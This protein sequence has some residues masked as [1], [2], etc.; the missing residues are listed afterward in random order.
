MVFLGWL[1]LC[2]GSLIAI[3]IWNIFWT[4]FGLKGLKQQTS[5]SSVTV[6]ADLSL[7]NRHSQD[8]GTDQPQKSRSCHCSLLTSP[9]L[10][11]LSPPFGCVLC[12]IISC[13]YVQNIYESLIASWLPTVKWKTSWLVC[14]YCVPR[15]D[16]Q[17]LEK[18]LRLSCSISV[19]FSGCVRDEVQRIA[20]I[21][22]GQATFG[23]SCLI[24]YLTV[25]WRK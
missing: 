20:C 16:V 4:I 24:S 6:Q 15:V 11:F 17:E 13:I 14:F 19:S 25:G 9:L 5:Y 21:L 2:L 7:L 23:C 18:S 8:M 1:F 10:Y 12:N 22:F 3:K